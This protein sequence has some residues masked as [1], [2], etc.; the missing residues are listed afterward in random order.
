MRNLTLR[1]WAKVLASLFLPQT[2]NLTQEWGPWSTASFL[3]D[4]QQ[5]A[6]RGHLGTDESPTSCL[7]TQDL[8]VKVRLTSLHL[9]ISLGVSDAA[10]SQ[11]NDGKHGMSLP[12]IG[13][14][15][16]VCVCS[17]TYWEFL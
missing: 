2:W 11:S 1:A 17:V 16:L 15:K 10:G 13:A 4:S 14:R 6:H 8:E 9:R 3:C 7:L 5:A 12:R